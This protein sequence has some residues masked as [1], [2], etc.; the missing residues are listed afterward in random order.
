MTT[1]ESN[2]AALDHAYAAFARRDAEELGRAYAD[3]ATFED[4]VF[5]RL[6][7]TQTRRMWSAL[8]RSETLKITYSV[9]ADATGGIVNWTANYVLNGRP[10]HNVVT[11]RIKLRDGRIAEQHDTFDFPR[12]VAQAVG[13]P[14]ATLAKTPLTRWLV[15]ALIRAK[16]HKRV[17]I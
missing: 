9:E 4:P 2:A 3:D 7:A 16:V 10:V 13:G 8:L 14:M 5:G 1:L 6:D 11:S 17:G 12:W 15:R